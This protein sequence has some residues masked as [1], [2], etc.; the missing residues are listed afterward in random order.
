MPACSTNTET[1]KRLS[2]GSSETHTSHSHPI[3]GTPVEVP[4]P[5]KVSF[6]R[7]EFRAAL[8]Q[9]SELL[10]PKDVVCREL[11]RRLLFETF[12]GRPNELNVL[13][14]QIGEKTVEKTR[15]LRMK[16]PFR[17]VAQHSENIEPILSRIEIKLPLSG[18]RMR[19]R[20]KCGG[21]IR[22]ERR[23]EIDE[24]RRIVCARDIVAFGSG[25]F[26]RQFIFGLLRHSRLGRRNG[27]RF[28]ART[29]RLSFDTFPETSVEIEFPFIAD[30]DDLMF[31]FSF[32]HLICPFVTFD[33]SISRKKNS[34]SDF[35]LENINQM[36]KSFDELVSVMAR[37][38]AP[39]GCPWDREQTYASLAQYLIEECYETIDA[40]HEA[41]ESGSTHNLSEELGDILLQVV[42]HSAIGAERGDFTI[43]DVVR[44]VTQ[45]LVLRHPHVFGEKDLKTA[46][47]V[48]NNWD[49]L[50]K[51][52][53]AASGKTAKQVD[54]ILEEVPV[55]FPALLEGQKITKKAAKVKFDWE[56]VDQIFDKLDEETRE[57]RAAIASGGNI[58]E[59]IGDLLFV[60]VNLARKLDVDAETA[61][62]KTNRKFRRRFRFIE[63]ELSSSGRGFEETDLS[64]LDAIWNRAKAE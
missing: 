60:A 22:R 4:V 20:A 8:G 3:V 37:L 56:N 53:R 23:K 31:F 19:H 16:I 34:K 6:I 55:H 33:S 40:I 41:D 24:A 49:D 2:R 28:F 17:F 25:G 14:S 44:S 39:G 1:R 52:E 63:D 29:R 42:F 18:R 64:E 10:L 48:L 57:L 32:A 35:V 21:G 7:S 13:H 62:K 51:A 38:R 46:E 9:Y 58:E 30:L 15:F 43:E 26:S 11:L 61:L 59:E 45:K 36:S 50:K 47:D 5:R 27:F 12:F 54:S